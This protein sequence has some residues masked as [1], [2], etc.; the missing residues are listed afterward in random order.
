VRRSG[1]DFLAN[2]HIFAYAL[3]GI[4]MGIK[5]DRDGNVYAGCADGVEVWSPGGTLLGVIEVQGEWSLGQMIGFRSQNSW[6]A[7]LTSE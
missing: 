7:L 3:R 4:P 5:C 6:Y 1:A 2:K